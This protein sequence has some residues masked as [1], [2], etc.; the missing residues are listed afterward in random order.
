MNTDDIKF[1]WFGQEVDFSKLLAA[2]LLDSSMAGR[3]AATRPR[4]WR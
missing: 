4:C 3:R 1:T 2:G